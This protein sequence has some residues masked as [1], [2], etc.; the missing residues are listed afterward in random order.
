[1]KRKG[2]SPIIA[3]VLLVAVSLA[4]AGIFSGWAPEMVQ[5][6]TDSTEDQADQRITC[7]R[8]SLDISSANLDGDTV[9][10]AVRNN[11]DEDLDVTAA[12]VDEDG[13]PVGEQDQD[14]MIP[15][16]ELDTLEVTGAGDADS[17]EVFTPDCGD[18][19]ASEVL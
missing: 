4:V 1:M 17:V 6:F 16:G 13:I 2:I 15:S 11:G 9:E 7:D 18:V 19:T 5:T 10:V 14:N 3:S 8:A 12:A